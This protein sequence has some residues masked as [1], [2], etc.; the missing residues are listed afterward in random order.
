MDG[1]IVSYWCDRLLETVSDG[2]DK[3]LSTDDERIVGLYESL[4]SLV[5]LPVIERHYQAY[6]GGDNSIKSV[7]IAFLKDA[8]EMRGF[9]PAMKAAVNEQ[10]DEPV[11]DDRLIL[12]REVWRNGA[13]RKKIVEAVRLVTS[14]SGKRDECDLNASVQSNSSMTLHLKALIGDPIETTAQAWVEAEHANE[15]I[16]TIGDLRDWLRQLLPGLRNELNPSKIAENILREH[17]N[18]FGQLI[19]RLR[20]TYGDYP[21][22]ELVDRCYDDRN[23]LLLIEIG[24]AAPN[25]TDGEPPPPKVA[26][27]YQKLQEYAG[28]KWTIGSDKDRLARSLANGPNDYQTVLDNLVPGVDRSTQTKRFDAIKRAA[29]VDLKR[30]GFVLEIR[31][32]G[33]NKVMAGKPI[34]RK[35]T[36]TKRKK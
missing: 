29:N 5:G 7:G 31:K 10:G 4:E 20:A 9:G 27:E 22:S 6:L 32:D 21:L 34:A 33:P 18:G 28:M 3:P 13:V 15:R 1:K 24:M 14:E 36:S 30:D 23:N 19:T 11:A 16:K 2:A 12:A 17:L 26:P 35:K 25:G 8:Y